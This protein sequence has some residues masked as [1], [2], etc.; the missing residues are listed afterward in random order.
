MEAKQDARKGA[1]TCTK[2]VEFIQRFDG[3]SDFVR[4]V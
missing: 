3:I 1:P 4:Q 2:R